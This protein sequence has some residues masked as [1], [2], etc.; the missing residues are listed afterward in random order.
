MMR[1]FGLSIAIFRS[2]LDNDCIRTGK[3]EAP[4]RNSNIHLEGF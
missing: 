2:I 3:K 4:V 1:R